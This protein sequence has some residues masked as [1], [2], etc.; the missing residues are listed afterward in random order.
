MAIQSR[1]PAFLLTRPSAQSQ[2][3]A[4][5]L[6]QRFGADLTIVISPLMQPEFAP[7]QVPAGPFGAA[8]FTSETGVQAYYRN[9]GLFP[10]TSK[11]V[12][13]V[14]DRTALAATAAGLDPVSAGGDADALVALILSQHPSGTLLHLC[15]AE[16]RG[17]VAQ[18]LTQ[19][20][21][22]TLACITYHQVE[23]PLT[24]DAIALLRGESPVVVPL[25]SPRSSALFSA[26]IT[27]L[28][29]LAPLV[30]VVL[31]KAVADPLRSQG[32]KLL[33]AMEP[34]AAAMLESVAG[35]FDATQMP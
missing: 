7:P 25:F 30:C 28:S 15:G 8:I 34:T 9:P 32:V 10:L 12:F 4:D 18:R 35:A 20:G 19:G 29:P 22:P 27:D 23:Q 1:L 2:R 33:Y 17:D 11:T 14:G 5:M 24:S 31:S 26:Q 6:R 21:V 13:C 3:F 16:T